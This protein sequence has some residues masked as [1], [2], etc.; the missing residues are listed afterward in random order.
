MWLG[1]GNGHRI[2][3]TAEEGCMFMTLNRAYTVLTVD[4]VSDLEYLFFL[5][6]VWL[7][8]NSIGATP[9]RQPSLKV[10]GVARLAGLDLY[11]RASIV[12]SMINVFN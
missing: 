4:A 3:L 12:F 1:I 6:W 11:V 9:T 8:S 2:L 5:Q 10:F 7:V